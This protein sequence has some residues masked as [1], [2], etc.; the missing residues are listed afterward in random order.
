MNLLKMTVFVLIN[1]MTFFVST[2]FAGEKLTQ[3]IYQNNGKMAEA[4]NRSLPQIGNPSAY[5]IYTDSV[6]VGSQ[7]FVDI[8]NDEKKIGSN[9]V[10]EKAWLERNKSSGY[11]SSPDIYIRIIGTFGGK[12]FY[13]TS[14]V[15]V[16]EYGYA[17]YPVSKLSE[18]DGS[19]F[20]ISSPSTST[21]NLNGMSLPTGLSINVDAIKSKLIGAYF[22]GAYLDYIPPKGNSSSSLNCLT[23][24]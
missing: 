6:P 17:P 4:Y 10:V 23:D 8:L 19:K 3:W 20:F 7:D 21:V 24:N 5:P 18:P 13:F 9:C 16:S 12:S 11:A 1:I 14:A 15:P 22:T 2:S